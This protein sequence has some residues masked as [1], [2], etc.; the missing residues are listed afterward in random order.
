[1]I[2]MLRGIQKTSILAN[3][4]DFVAQR[5]WLD[6]EATRAHERWNANDASLRVPRVDHHQSDRLE[7]VAGLHRL[8]STATGRRRE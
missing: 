8:G 7:S 6:Q 2:N 3:G 5:A 1:M 4:G